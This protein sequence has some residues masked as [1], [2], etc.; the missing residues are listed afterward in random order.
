MRIFLKTEDEINLLRAASQLVS[1]A[2]T[3]VGRH[4]VTMVALSHLREKSISA[5]RTAFENEIRNACQVSSFQVNFQ[6]SING[7][8]IAFSSE[9]N[10][11]LSVGDSFTVECWVCIEGLYSFGATTFVVGLSPSKFGSYLLPVR[12]ALAQSLTKAVAGHSLHELY[13]PFLSLRDN[14]RFRVFDDI[15]HGIGRCLTESPFLRLNGNYVG[16]QLLKQGM[17]LVVAPRIQC[18]V[19]PLAMKSFLPNASLAYLNLFYAQTLIV[20]SGKPEILTTL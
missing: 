15:G 16:H 20:R 10:V 17:C 8:P 12:K 3:E 1:K 14:N 6:F 7:A 2:L 19:S 11:C 13:Q 18:T 4:V 9:D 5:V